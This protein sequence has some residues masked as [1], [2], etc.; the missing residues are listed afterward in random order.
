M[1][2]SSS[3]QLSYDDYTVGWVAVLPCEIDAARLVFEN[4]HESLPGV[5]GD[6]NTYILA[7]V[8][9]HN[10]VLTFP[11]LGKTGVAAVTTCATNMMRTFT[12]IQF[13]LVVGVASGAPRAPDLEDPSKDLRLG[14]VVVSYPMNGRAGVVQNDF[15]KQVEPFDFIIRF[16][17]D[18]PSDKLLNAASALSSEH[19]SGEGGMLNFIQMSEQAAR[20]AGLKGHCFP[21]REKDQLFKS[22]Y[23]HV[24][25]DNTDCSACDIQQTELRLSRDQE[26]PLVHHGLVASGSAAIRSSKYRDAVG[27][28]HGVLCFETGAAAGTMNYYPSL[29]IRGIC[30]YADSHANELWK[31]YAATTAASYARDLL[32]VLVVPN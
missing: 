31:S 11:P 6:N 15:G 8:E 28:Q 21:G 2:S 9:R 5:E 18:N 30:D 17:I 4:E 7:D 13:I 20:T 23:P 25:N 12:N 1:H 14:D 32:R 24:D 26:K 10:M 19:R 27:S 22:S 16:D 3:K 29:A